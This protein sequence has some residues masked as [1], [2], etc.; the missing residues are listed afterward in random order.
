LHKSKEV[1]EY[2]TVTGYLKSM[3]TRNIF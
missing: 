2:V 1:A 3:F